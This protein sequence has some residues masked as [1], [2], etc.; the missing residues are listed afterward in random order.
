[1]FLCAALHPHLYQHF[2]SLC[3]SFVDDITAYA[4]RLLTAAHFSCARF[5]AAV[6]CGALLL[7]AR[8]LG[9]GLNDILQALEKG[10]VTLAEAVDSIRKDG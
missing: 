7:S 3:S 9:E 6:Y 8:A 5:W 10:S 1:M 4:R 2:A